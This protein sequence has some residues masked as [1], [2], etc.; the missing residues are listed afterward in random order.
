MEVVPGA[1]ELCHEELVGGGGGLGI[2]GL[3]GLEAGEAGV[4]EDLVADLS[5]KVPDAL[6]GQDAHVDLEAQQ[7][8]HRQ[9]EHGQYDHIP[10]VF[11]RF[12]Y[13]T[14]DCFQTWKNDEVW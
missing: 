13:G 12:D 3:E 8:E 4:A 7:G 6:L 11:H 2:V 10:E 14:N 1:V 5:R 9:R